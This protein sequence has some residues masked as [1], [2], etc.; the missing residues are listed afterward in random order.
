MAGFD[1]PA[2]YGDRWAAVYDELHRHADPGP[3]V[4]FLASLAGDGRVLELAIGTGR[5]ALPLAAR[6]VT[7][8][9][10]DTSAAMVDRLRAKPDGDAILVTLGDMAQVPVSGSFRLVYLVFNT[11]FGLLSQERQAECFAS[12]AHV[13]DPGGMFVIECFILDLTRF[14]HDQRVQARSVM[15]D[16]AIIEVSVHDRARQRVTTQMVTLDGQ[17]M[18]LRPVAIRYSYPA[19]L[20]LMAGVAGLRLAE[21]YAD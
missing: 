21:R 13:L 2:F 10:I 3:A 20:D 17:G 8:E 11:L 18:H 19:E 4:K 16:S 6:G 1:D 14:D 7:V 15:Q 5:V 9:G 12:V